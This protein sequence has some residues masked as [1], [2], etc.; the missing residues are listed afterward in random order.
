[1][2]GR[3]AK[4][5][6]MK[7]NLIH[8]VAGA[9]LAAVVAVTAADAQAPPAAQLGPEAPQQQGPEAPQPQTAPLLALPLAQQGPEAPQSQTAPLL[10]PELLNQMLAPI[11]LYP[12]ELLGE[13]LMAATYPLDVVE[14]ARW[15]QDPRNALLKGDQLIAALQQQNWDPSVKLLAPFPSILR[16]MDAKLEWAE[17]LGEAF[18]ADPKAVMDAVQRL[19]Q[20]ARLAGRLVSGPQ[21][22]VQTAQGE[23]T[24]E[25]PTPE[26][27]YVPVC[28]PSL[29]YG[30]CGWESWPIVPQFSGLVVLDFRD[31]HIHI[32]RDLF[33][34]IDKK[35][36][37]IGGEEW[38]H[39]PL[40]RGNVPYR[41]PEVAARYGAAAPSREILSG[42]HEAQTGS[43]PRID[44]PFARTLPEE[45]HVPQLERV[46]PNGYGYVARG[47]LLE[48]EGIDP[49]RKTIVPRGS[50]SLDRGAEVQGQV[51]RGY[52]TRTPAPG[53]G[54]R[55]V[56]PYISRLAGGGVRERPLLGGGMRGAPLLG[57][58]MRQGP[59]PGG[60]P[61]GS[62]IMGGGIMGGGIRA[63]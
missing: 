49:D 14:A 25:A 59:S 44:G 31:H 1:L 28:D 62:G 51:E 55:S 42:F 9:V 50:E 40:H 15:L 52:S 46:D 6:V 48:L 30:A 16:M 58:N 37:P 2:R 11:A 63:H 54:P 17:R 35:R 29:I 18:L 23:I 56:R 27:I 34:L 61:M 3:R 7:S 43:P 13:I 36:P 41:D 33:A 8:A 26:I 38:R 57:S 53:W 45:G 12:D 60:G 47:T 22:I 5:L 32:A 24:I 10:T 4:A 20:R 21:E 39:D 19:R